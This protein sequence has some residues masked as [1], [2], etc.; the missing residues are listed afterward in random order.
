[1][2]IHVCLVFYIISL[3]IC[4][5]L[6]S[7][8]CFY[9]LMYENICIQMQRYM[10]EDWMIKSQNLLCGNYLFNQDLLVNIFKLLKFN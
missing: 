9:S 7:I 6:I 10:L 5:Y 1:M 8:M 4:L 2:Y 3:Y